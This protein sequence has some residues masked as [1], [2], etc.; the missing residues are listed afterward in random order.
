MLEKIK[1]MLSSNSYIYIFQTKQTLEYYHKYYSIFRFFAEE[2][3]V[4]DESCSSTELA[5]S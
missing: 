4:A 3:S 2:L 5:A 1:E